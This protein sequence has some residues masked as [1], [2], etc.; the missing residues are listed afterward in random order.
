MGFYLRK[1]VS[2][3]PLRFNLSKSGVGVSAGVKGFRVGMGPRGNYVHMGRGGLYYRATLP[4]SSPS[5]LRDR[6]GPSNPAIPPGTHD[7]LE[8]IDSGDVS[9]IVDSSSR[10]LLAEL[11]GKRQRMRL[12]PYAAAASVFLIFVG[13]SSGWPLGLLGLIVV[14]CVAATYAAYSR[15]ILAKTV[16]LFYDFEPELEEAYGRLHSSA[17]RLAACASAWHI[18]AEGRVHDRKYHAGASSLIRRKPTSIRKAEPPYVKTNI[19][20]VAIGV[21][22]QTLHFFPDRVLVYDRNGVGAVGYRELQVGVSPSRFIESGVVPRDAKVVDHT[23]KYVN[24]SGGPDRRFKDNRQLPICLYDE[25]S[26]SS[27][28]G[29]NEVVQVSQSGV[30]H[31]FA[32]AVSYLGR[33]IPEEPDRSLA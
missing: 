16:V 7:P 33:K 5:Q 2:V 15:D 29:L 21:G 23:W 18:E 13:Y 1:S 30:A 8:E 11:N 17:E 6:E 9:R 25:V 22:R 3:G 32:E 28:T 10:D 24:K 19:E 26:L 31:G 4:A 27:R 12:W 14:L 20:T